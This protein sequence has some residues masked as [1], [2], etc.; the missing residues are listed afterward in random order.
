MSIASNVDYIETWQALEQ[1]V[2]DGLVKSIGVSNF[3]HEQIDRLL[4]V[5]KIKPAVNQVLMM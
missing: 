1:A 2:N 5:A 3:N 4:M